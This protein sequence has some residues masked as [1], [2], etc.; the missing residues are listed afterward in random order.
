MQVSLL[1]KSGFSKRKWHYSC[2]MV[3]FTTNN[4]GI[5]QNGESQN[6]CYKKSKDDKLS[7]KQTFL[8]TLCVSEGKCSFFGKLG[9]L[10]FLVTLVSRFV[11]YL[12]TGNLLKASVVL[13]QKKINKLTVYIFAKCVKLHKNRRILLVTSLY[14]VFFTYKLKSKF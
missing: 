7:E 4:S 2:K 13:R 10:C 11:L 6:G 8:T 3:V 12:I 9:V 1:S 14:L 5:S